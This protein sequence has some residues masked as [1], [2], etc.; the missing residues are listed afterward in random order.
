MSSFLQ[1]IFIIMVL[2]YKRK[3]LVNSF[4]L[5][6]CVSFITIFLLFP[7]VKALL[8]TDITWWTIN[9]TAGFVVK[10][11]WALLWETSVLGGMFY[12]IAKKIF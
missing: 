10:I 11:F 3:I 4:L 2:N 7:H 12:I 9:L 5:A 6:F 1:S 8:F